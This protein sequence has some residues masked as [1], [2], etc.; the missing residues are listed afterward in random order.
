[1]LINQHK[2]NRHAAVRH[3]LLTPEVDW[4]RMLAFVNMIKCLN[5]F[6]RTASFAMTEVWVH[7]T[8]LLKY[9]SKTFS[10]Q[11]LLFSSGASWY[12]ACQ[13]RTKVWATTPAQ[14]AMLIQPSLI[15]LQIRSERQ[16]AQGKGGEEGWDKGGRPGGKDGG[17]SRRD[18][19][20][21][22]KRE[23]EREWDFRQAKIFKMTEWSHLS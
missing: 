20:R 18:K 10:P 1:M 17:W 22:K 2:Q 7:L 21:G 6:S 8:P 16:A 11:S 12:M 19:R 4:Y 15:S 13:R 5:N 14:E 3:K 9:V 23:Y